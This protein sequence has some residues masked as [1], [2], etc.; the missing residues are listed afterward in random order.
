MKADLANPEAAAPARAVP[1]ARYLSRASFLGR[2]GDLLTLAG[3]VAAPSYGKGIGGINGLP[4]ADIILGAAALVRVA[5]ALTEGVPRAGLRLRSV[6]L[7]LLAVFAVAG[8]TSAIAN[9]QPLSWAFIRV[10]IATAGTVLLVSVYGDGEDPRPVVTALALGTAVLAVSSFTGYKLHGRS[11]GWSSHPNQL[12]HSCMIGMFAAGWLWDTASDR[13]LRRL[14]VGV[15]LLDLIAVNR[16]GSRGALIGLAAGGFVYLWLRGSI[17]LRAAALAAVWVVL[18]VIPTGIVVLPESNPLGR[19]LTSNKKSTSANASDQ[20]RDVLL[21]ASWAKISAH[22]ILG[23]GFSGVDLGSGFKGID[24]VHV[25]Y[26]QGWIGAGAVGGFLIML[27]GGIL[28]VLPFVQR[29]RDLALACGGVAIAAAWTVTNMLT[30]RDQW[31]CIAAIFATVRPFPLRASA[32]FALR[33]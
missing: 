17:R 20:Q 1:A 30:V 13:R 27:I 31:I 6:L 19:L 26:L 18:L 3:A 2:T 9:D 12:G 24:Q 14:W 7:S 23:T 5:Q 28:L 22:P 21:S 10:V 8:L 15:V 4:Y 33:T 32:R 11:L 16:S 25:V 29:R